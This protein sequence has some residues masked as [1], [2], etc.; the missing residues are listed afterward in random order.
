MTGTVVVSNLSVFL[1]PLFP[2]LPGDAWSHKL[3]PH[4]PSMILFTLHIRRVMIRLMAS[5]G[6]LGP[7]ATVEATIGAKD[8]IMIAPSNT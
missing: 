1:K 3:S 6:L 4:S 8:K 7:L 2:S 5:H